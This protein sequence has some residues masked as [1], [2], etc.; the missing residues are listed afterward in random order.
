MKKT[1]FTIC[2]LLAASSACIAGCANEQPKDTNPDDKEPTRISIEEN[3]GEKKCPDG[4]N[5]P[6]NGCPK[7]GNHKGGAEHVKPNFRFVPPEETAPKED[8]AK[9]QSPKDGVKEKSPENAKGSFGK[10]HRFDKRFKE[11]APEKGDDTPAPEV[12]NDG[13]ATPKDSEKSAK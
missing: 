4:E 1:I 3:G 6:K 11:P 7:N 9:S 10:K 2:A 5:C 13:D 12:K 8:G